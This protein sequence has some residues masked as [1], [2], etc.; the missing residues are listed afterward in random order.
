MIQK[1]EFKYIIV[2]KGEC[3][4]PSLIRSS[5]ELIMN[6]FINSFIDVYN[7][8]KEKIEVKVKKVS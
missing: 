8:E 6:T 7:T 3:I 2:V 1:F 4:K 5:F